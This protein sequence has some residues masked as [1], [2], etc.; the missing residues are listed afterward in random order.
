MRFLLDINQTGSNPLLSLDQLKIYVA[1]VATY[2]TL[3]DLSSFATQI[4]DMGVGNK[5]YL[6][7]ALESG[8]GAGDMLAYLPYNLFSAHQTKY[9]YLVSQ[10]GATG[11][12]YATN[13]GFE[14]WARV[15]GAAVTP[16]P[17]P[18][19]LLLLGSGLVGA[20]FMRRR[21]SV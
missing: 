7:Y 15:D 21:R 18:A 12:D 11:G 6:N 13:D 19:S 10:F 1:P 17:E 2:N 14:E 9:L 4:Y 16:V 3:A 5:V 20:A 8:S